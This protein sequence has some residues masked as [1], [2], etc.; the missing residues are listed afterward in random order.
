MG[1][2][3]SIDL[4]DMILSVTILNASS[5]GIYRLWLDGECRVSVGE[6]RGS[7]WPAEDQPRRA[8]PQLPPTAKSLNSARVAFLLFFFFF[9]PY[10]PFH[11]NKRE[12]LPPPTT[13][14]KD[15][16]ANI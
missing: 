5:I 1:Q 15:A 12:C 16:L 11:S 2:T 6:S 7:L 9:S 4:G 13:H 14:R 10:E 8:T 3:I